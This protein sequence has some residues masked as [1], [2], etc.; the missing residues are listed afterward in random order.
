MADLE[1]YLKYQ[2]RRRC[3]AE[4]V[5]VVFEPFVSVDIV[6]E[7]FEELV[8]LFFVAVEN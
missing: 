6:V 3:F 1:L 4:E 7:E 2:I 5:V 8:E